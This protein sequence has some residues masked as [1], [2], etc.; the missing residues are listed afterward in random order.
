MVRIRRS[1]YRELNHRT[2]GGSHCE[3][4]ELGNSLAARMCVFGIQPVDLMQDPTD[5]DAF[6][7]W[8]A[9][10]GGEVLCGFQSGTDQSEVRPSGGF[11]ARVRGAQS[12][13]GSHGPGVRRRWRRLVRT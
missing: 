8:M 1:K 13:D 7:L 10:L 6:A 11:K 4:A 3:T 9:G 2:N 12:A 5:V